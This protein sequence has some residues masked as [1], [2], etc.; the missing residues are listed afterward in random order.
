MHLII[1]TF[2]R[3]P[4]WLTFTKFTLVE[5]LTPRL[6]LDTIPTDTVDLNNAVLKLYPRLGPRSPRRHQRIA[7]WLGQGVRW[8]ALF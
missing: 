7:I 5:P 8:G 4:P 2:Y 3:S 1:K 6:R